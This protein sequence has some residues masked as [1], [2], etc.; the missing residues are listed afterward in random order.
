M[1]PNFTPEFAWAVL[2]LACLSNY[3]F[4]GIGALLSGRLSAEG[5][6]FKWVTAVTYAL[7]TSLTARL[8]LYPSSMLSHVPLAVRIGVAVVTMGVMLTAPAKRMIP[9]LAC[10]SALTLIYGFYSHGWA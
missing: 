8:L 4:R 5:E 3:F 6:F 2:A 10:G 9:A 7:M 1:T